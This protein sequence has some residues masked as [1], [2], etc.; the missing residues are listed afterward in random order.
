MGRFQGD[1]PKRTFE[2][3]RQIVALI[4]ALPQDTR[5][6]V[7]GKQLLRSGTSIG[8]NVREADVAMSDA[9]FAQRCSVA[10][11]EAS[12]TGYWIALCQSAGFLG[13]AAAESA[14]CEADELLHILSAIVKKTQL[15]RARHK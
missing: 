1:L 4:G 2:F 11:K 15:H 13:D 14:L 8:A 7:L 10:R 3:A 6:W 9:E 5:G 12:E